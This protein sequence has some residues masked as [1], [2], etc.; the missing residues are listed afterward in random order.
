[1]EYRWADR[2]RLRRADPLTGGEVSGR[3]RGNYTSTSPGSTMCGFVSQPQ[4]ECVADVF[5]PIVARH[6]RGEIV[7]VEQWWSLSH[8]REVI[9]G[10]LAQH[11]GDFRGV[12]PWKSR[13]RSARQQLDEGDPEL[14]SENR[15]PHPRRRKF[16]V[17]AGSFERRH[18]QNR[19]QRRQAVIDPDPVVIDMPSQRLAEFAARRRLLL[20]Q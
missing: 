8:Q 5:R 1:M 20:E 15:R 16:Q 13:P 7:V 2:A 14:L 3:K 11:R 12:G 6:R 19:D 18:A 10:Q 17:T 4:P 9:V